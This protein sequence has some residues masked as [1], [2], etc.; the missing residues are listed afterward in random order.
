MS[1]SEG[2]SFGGLKDFSVDA[3]RRM[4]VQAQERER[5]AAENKKASRKIKQTTAGATNAVAISGL[6]SNLETG[7]A[8]L[9]TPTK[10]KMQLVGEDDDD[11]IADDWSL[12]SEESFYVGIERADYAQPNNLEMYG[13][14]KEEDYE[15]KEDRLGISRV[16]VAIVNREGVNGGK[17]DWD[18]D[19][20]IHDEKSSSLHEFMN[21]I[22]VGGGSKASRA[23]RDVTVAMPLVGTSLDWK[24]ESKLGEDDAAIDQVYQHKAAEGKMFIDKLVGESSNASPGKDD[25]STVA[26][27]ATP[28]TAVKSVG[29]GGTYPALSPMA[30]FSPGITTPGADKIVDGEDNGVRQMREREIRKDASADANNKMLSLK[31]LIATTKDGSGKVDA[32]VL[33]KQLEKMMQE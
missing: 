6:M 12:D 13:E 2:A 19:I 17:L 11:S 15:V 20:P 1:E 33:M 23:K 21:G 29:G 5:Q 18:A 3:Q 27:M 25:T 31:K 24:E 9:N 16:S 10:S 8:G 26:A 14:E 28:G 4:F 7:G 22:N 32:F 30:L